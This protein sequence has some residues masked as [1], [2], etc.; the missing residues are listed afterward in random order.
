MEDRNRRAR[1][2]QDPIRAILYEDWAPFGFIEDLPR[3]EYDAYIGAVYRL[4]ASG[5]NEVQVAEHLAE[6][7]RGSFGYT[8]ASAAR[9]LNA[10]KKLCQLSVYL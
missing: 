8:E 9:N 1:E 7:E 3:D 2:I 5:A 6:V 10:A 4:L